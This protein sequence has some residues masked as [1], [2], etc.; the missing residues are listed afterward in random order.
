[1][2][3]SE[4]VFIAFRLINVALLL[5]IFIEAFKRIIYPVLKLQLAAAVD[6]FNKLYDSITHA[7]NEYRELEHALTAKRAEGVML[8]HKVKLWRAHAQKE[9]ERYAEECSVRAH[10]MGAVRREQ[11]TNFVSTSTRRL[12][13]VQV[14]EQTRALLQKRFVDERE[15]KRFLDKLCADIQREGCA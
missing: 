6:V 15:G 2:Q 10:A 13:G 14:I 9:H 5:G 8:L 3:Q 12:V 4:V 11:E 7:T 1:M